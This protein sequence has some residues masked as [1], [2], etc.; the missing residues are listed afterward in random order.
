MTVRLLQYAIVLA[1]V[2]LAI[3]L[4]PAIQTHP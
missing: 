3:W 2:I 1:V 4:F